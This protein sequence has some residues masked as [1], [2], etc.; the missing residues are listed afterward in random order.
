VD[1]VTAYEAAPGYQAQQSTL[2]T[3]RGFTFLIGI[4]VIGGFFQIQTLQKVPRIGTL[5]AI[6]AS[7]F[8]VGVAVVTQILIV[9]ALGVL[10]GSLGTLGLS[11]G[12]PQGIPIR[13]TPETATAAIL[14]LLV[15]GPVG[16]LVSV[17]LALKVEPLMALGLSA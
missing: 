3:Q 6:G 7:N 10:V 5:K 8:T 9:T 16:G 14:S 15:I 2:N 11:L 17:R 1:P 13:F 12:L 4:L